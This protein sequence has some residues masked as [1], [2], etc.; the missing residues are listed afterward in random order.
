MRITIVRRI[1]QIFF[2][3]LFVWFCIASTF[4][5]SFWQLR[6]W[7]VN[8]FFQLDPLVGLGTILTTRTLYS[9]LLW[10]VATVALTL[11]LGRFF[12]GWL[13]P[14]GAM[15]HFIGYL[16]SLGRSAREKIT[17]NRYMGSQRIKYYILLILLAPAAGALLVNIADSSEQN[18]LVI[19]GIICILAIAVA[20]SRRA[21]PLTRRSVTVFFGLAAF[22]AAAGYFLKLDGAVSASLMTGL[23]DPIPLVY[24]SV[25]FLL[26]PFADSSFHLISAAQRHYE[27]AW[28][29]ASIFFAALFLNLAIPRFYCRFVCPLGRSLWCFRQ[30][31]S[32]ADRKENRRM[33]PMQALRF[34]VRRRLR[35]GGTHP[36][37]RMRALHELP[38]HLQ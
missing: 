31:R 19:A 14:F 4:G 11:L 9:G 3:V 24:R 17:V 2:F 27:G 13:C 8:W 15:H 12:C 21:D 32:V 18:P 30:I 26:L 34:Q 16:G 28:L 33:Q 5:Q 22:W 6:N 25:N 38:L 35:P 29:T 1:S 23:L 10:A 7:P 37:P 20:V 36:D